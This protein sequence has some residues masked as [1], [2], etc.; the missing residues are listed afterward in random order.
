VLTGIPW[1]LK[2]EWVE[3]QEETDSG[4]TMMGIEKEENM[5]TEEGGGVME[6]LFGGDE[7]ADQDM[8]MDM[9]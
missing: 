5:E 8:D 9:E 4:Y 3:E 1:G 2:G 7:D 6:D